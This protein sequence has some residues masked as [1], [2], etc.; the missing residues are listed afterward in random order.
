M[1]EKDK[2]PLTTY[3]KKWMAITMTVSLIDLQF[4]FLLAFFG[5]PE[6][7]ETLAVSIVVNI[8]SVFLVYCAKSFFE[9]KEEKKNE[10][11]YEQWVEEI[12]NRKESK[13]DSEG[14]G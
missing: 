7:A 9:T 2:K 10:L 4:P 1:E 5:K 6:I 14:V 8:I 3:T 12:K 11:M 13:D